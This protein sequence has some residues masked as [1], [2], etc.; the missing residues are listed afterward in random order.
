VRNWSRWDSVFIAEVTIAADTRRRDQEPG[1][2]SRCNDLAIGTYDNYFS[3]EEERLGPQVLDDI[4]ELTGGRAFAV[5]N[6][7]DLEDV[8]TK[9]GIELCSDRASPWQARS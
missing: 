9:I 6:P 1:R 2:G 8:A 7:N 5:G 4:A 3:T